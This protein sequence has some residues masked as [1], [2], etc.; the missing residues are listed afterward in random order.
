MRR[1]LLGA[2]FAT[3]TLVSA[4]TPIS[5]LPAGTGP[6]GV[7]IQLYGSGISEGAFDFPL[8][9]GKPVGVETITAE[10]GQVIEFGEGS[11]IVSV[12]GGS[13]SHYPD[14]TI[15]ETWTAGH[16]YFHS[17]SGHPG[18]ITV[19]EGSGPATLVL[20]KSGA[21]AVAAPAGGS[22]DHGHG[23]GHDGGGAPLPMAA[24]GH[25]HGMTKV[26]GCPAAGAVA[27]VDPKGTGTAFNPDT[28]MQQHDHMQVQVWLFRF[29]PGYT[30]DWHTH[31]GA[32]IAVQ[33][34]GVIENWNGCQEKETW[35]PGYS[36]FH[37]PGTHGQHQ[38]LT[39]NKTDAQSELVA[40]FF[41]VPPEYGNVVPPVVKS[42]PP[43][44]C[45]TSALT[46]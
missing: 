30:S 15:K 21:T 2:L 16:T 5:A 41:N 38:N 1:S 42:P 17:S 11:T 34:K 40:I 29:E 6:V 32:A 20:V 8:Q 4:A 14:C 36:Y 10:P 19:N 27:P 18:A 23:G 45:P 35:D 37:S 25:D 44:E 12:T 43:A 46:Y 3:V 13:V 26:S 28:V 31:P 7:T 24:G 9:Q 39:N 33:T 22:H